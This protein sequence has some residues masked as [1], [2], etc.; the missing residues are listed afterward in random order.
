MRIRFPGTGTAPGT[1]TMSRQ[2]RIGATAD[3]PPGTVVGVGHYA[4][5]GKAFGGTP[6]GG[7]VTGCCQPDLDGASPWES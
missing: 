4:V 3:L 2:Q 5:A 6:A 1:R 7:W